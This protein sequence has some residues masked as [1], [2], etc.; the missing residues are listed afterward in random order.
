MHFFQKNKKSLKKIL[1]N[2][3]KGCIIDRLTQQWP[4]GQ[5]VKT[6]ASHAENMGSIPV[7]VTK[8]KRTLLEGVLFVLMT[9]FAREPLLKIVYFQDMGSK[10]CLVVSCGDLARRG[11]FPYGCSAQKAPHFSMK[12]LKVA[13]FLAQTNLNH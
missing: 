12:L 6:S 9:R 7:R 3:K 5:A 4:V 11:K 13:L 1:T 10:H 2:S 8:T